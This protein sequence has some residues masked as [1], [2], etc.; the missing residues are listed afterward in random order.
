MILMNLSKI[1][2]IVLTILK[3]KSK[4]IGYKIRSI[5]RNLNPQSLKLRFQIVMTLNLAYNF[6]GKHSVDK[7]GAF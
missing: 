3:C 1:Q 6:R 7:V 5:Q 2:T 4:I